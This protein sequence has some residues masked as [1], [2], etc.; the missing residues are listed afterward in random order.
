MVSTS[1]LVVA[2]R[3]LIP[4]SRR[5]TPRGILSV[6]H[7]QHNSP[8]SKITSKGSECK[9]IKST[10]AECKAV[11]EGAL[12]WLGEI[13]A[14]DY[15][16]I[17][18]TNCTSK[19]I[20]KL[21]IKYQ[22][23]FIKNILEMGAKYVVLQG[24]PATGCFPMPFVTGAPPTD[25]D[26][27]GCVASKNKES[28]HHNMILQAKL[29]SLQKKFS[30]SVIVPEMTGMRTVRGAPLSFDPMNTCGA[31]GENSCKDPS[32]YMNWD[33]LHVTE[34]MSKVVSKL[35]L[36]GGFAQP[37]YLDYKHYR[38]LFGYVDVNDINKVE[39]VVEENPIDD[40]NDLNDNLNDLAQ[41]LKEDEVHEH[42][43]NVNFQDQIHVPLKEET[44]V[45]TFSN[46]ETSDPS[47][48][49][50]FEHMK[51][52][53]SYTSKCSTSFPRHHKKDV[54]GISLIHELNRIIKKAMLD[55][56]SIDKKIDDGTV[57]QF[58]HDNRT[59]LLHDIDKF[60]NLEAFDLIQKDHI[61]WDIEGDENSKFFHGLINQKRRI[62]AITCIMH[63]GVWSSDLL[64]IKEIFLNFFKDKFQA[65]D[66]QVV[67]S[68]LALTTGLCTRDRE[69]LE[70]SVSCD[71]IKSAIWDCGSNKASGPDTS[72][73]KINIHK[74]NYGIGVS[75]EK[76][77]IMAYSIGCAPGSLPFTYLGLPISS[78]MNLIS[79]WQPLIDRFQSRLSSWKANM[80]SIGGRL[81]LIKAV[82]DSL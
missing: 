66:S 22:T 58:D 39:D 9:T 21:A 57:T 3:F 8:G 5:L 14:N 68:H 71:E 41:E 44:H 50:G 2:P 74:S 52:S 79:N 34:G 81:T 51:R 7:Y 12:V 6:N 48:P 64:F 82:L 69:S 60:V 37:P 80:L 17:F 25:R 56:M 67:F 61:K 42:D 70:T 47:R 54:K 45:P 55:L 20:Q 1:R 62:Q 40:L 63:D 26:D 38:Y 76:V 29:Q 24:L 19:T 32:R 16:Y 10:P 65:H 13:S 18:L 77:S 30:S 33:G 35:F 23:R 36:D 15:N 43:L 49:P 28:Y 53:P 46:G 4:F 27:I 75:I 31:P 72:G 59:K 73:L 11:F 78:N